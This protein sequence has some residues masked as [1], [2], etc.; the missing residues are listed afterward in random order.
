MSRPERSSDESG[1]EPEHQSPVFAQQ[2]RHA[3]MVNCRVSAASTLRDLRHAATSQAILAG[4]N[5]PPVGKLLGHRR[6]RTT[7]S[8]AHVL[9]AHLVEAAEKVGASFSRVMAVTETKCRSKNPVFPKRSLRSLIDFV[10]P[11]WIIGTKAPKLGIVIDGTRIGKY[12]LARN[13]ICNGM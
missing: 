13:G 4:E 9:D 7:A 5:L 8:Y 11:H 12:D 10:E 1:A 6:H 2:S 3:M